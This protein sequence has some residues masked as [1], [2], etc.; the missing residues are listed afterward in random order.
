MWVC[1][2]IHT[3]NQVSA[4]H[5]CTLL[6]RRLRQEDSLSPGFSGASLG[7]LVKPCLKKEKPGLSSRTPKVQWLEWAEP[8]GKLKEETPRSTEKAVLTREVSVAYT[9]KQEHLRQ[10]WIDHCGTQTH[11]VHIL[12]HIRTK[13]ILALHRGL[14]GVWTQSDTKRFLRRL[15]SLQAFRSSEVWCRFPPSWAPWEGSRQMEWVLLTAQEQAV[16]KILANDK[17]FSSK[18]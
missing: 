4:R 9:E 8:V 11:T 2:H 15:A 17:F 16:A 12:L 18:I 7:N 14:R 5:N 10:A 13:I 1:T 3:V 6:F